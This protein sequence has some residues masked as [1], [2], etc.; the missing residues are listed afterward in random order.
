LRL[1]CLGEV[2]HLREEQQGVVEAVQPFMPRDPRS[3]WCGIHTR[4]RVQPFPAQRVL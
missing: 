4:P 3:N 2:A 1:V